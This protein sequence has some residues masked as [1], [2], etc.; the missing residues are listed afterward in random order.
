MYRFSDWFSDKFYA[1]LCAEIRT[2]KGW[3]NP[4][5]QRNEQW[6]LSY[7]CIGLCVSEIIRIEHIDWDNP[8]GW[9]A[10]WD[11]NDLIRKQEAPKPFDNSVQSSYDFAQFG[12]ALA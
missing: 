9:A 3:E 8:P 11:K 12:A 6:D 1:E 10:E 5:N 7:M 4:S 2:E